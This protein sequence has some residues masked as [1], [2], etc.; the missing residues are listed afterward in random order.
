VVV[1]EFE[2]ETVL[3]G[4]LEDHPDVWD[5]TQAAAD[6]AGL[7]L[8]TELTGLGVYI[9]AINGTSASGWEYFLNGERGVVAVDEAA[10]NSTV[11]LR[12]RLA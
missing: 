11:V 6:E 10:V 4:G 2:D 12:W 5:L 3:V 9:T 8:T 7:T 1:F